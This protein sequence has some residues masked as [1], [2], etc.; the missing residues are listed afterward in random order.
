MTENHLLDLDN[1]IINQEL[2]KKYNL[3]QWEEYLHNDEI[4]GHLHKTQ[5]TEDLCEEFFDSLSEEQTENYFKFAVI[6]MQRFVQL[7]FTGPLLKSDDNF[8]QYFDRDL[9]T[10]DC[11]LKYLTVDN[12]EINVNTKLP[13]LLYAAKIIFKHSTYSKLVKSWWLLRTLIVHQ[14]IVD[15]VT[16]TLYNDAIALERLLEQFEINGKLTSL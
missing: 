5:G 2:L 9:F 16:M 13:C 3:E 10:N 1:Q 15:E 12:E 4:W 6:C 8:I 14:K 11:F 7:N